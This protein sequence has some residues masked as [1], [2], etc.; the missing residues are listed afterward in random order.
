MAK[1][2]KLPELTISEK[3]KLKQ[4]NTLNHRIA[5]FERQG[6][7]GTDAY[8]NLISSIQKAGFDLSG[9]NRIRESRKNITLLN[10]S[11]TVMDHLASAMNMPNVAVLR[12]RAR[13][14]FEK[15][16]KPTAQEITQRAVDLD[17]FHRWVGE[18]IN[19]LYGHADVLDKELQIMRAEGPKT[20]K[21]LLAVK[22]AMEKYE[23]VAHTTNAVRQKEIG[24][25]IRRARKERRKQESLRVRGQI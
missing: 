14:S 7:T 22:E 9:K 12:K 17:T 2:E 11:I 19:I 15:D 23:G 4:I 8:H 25:E 1:R 24:E 20:Y 10:E 16:E 13:A 3:E 18:N 5:A 21:E 6:M